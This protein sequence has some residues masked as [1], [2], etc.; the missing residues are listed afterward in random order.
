MRSTAQEKV[1]EFSNR[2]VQDLR[3]KAADAFQNARPVSDPKARASYLQ[4]A[5]GYLEEALKDYPDAT[6][7][8]TVRDNLR[9]I[10]R[11]LEQLTGEKR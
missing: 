10:T 8:P 1:K 5:K 11:D 4:Q 9:M 3:R 6:L 7:L 2:G